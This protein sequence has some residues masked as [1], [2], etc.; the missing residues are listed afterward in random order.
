MTALKFDDKNTQLKK[1][2]R[3]FCS[4]NTSGSLGLLRK[5]GEILNRQKNEK[6]ENRLIVL[7]QL[8]ASINESYSG[9]QL[10]KEFS[11]FITQELSMTKTPE[12]VFN[13]VQKY[14]QD[15][16]DEVYSS[17]RSIA[18]RIK[19][20]LKEKSV[21]ITL[22]MSETVLDVLKSLHDTGHLEKVIVSESR[23]MNEGTSMAETLANYGIRTE[24]VVDAALDSMVDSADCAIIGSDTVYSDGSVSNKIGSRGLSLSCLD[25]GKPF[26]VL[27]QRRKFSREISSTFSCDEKPGT[28]I[29]ELSVS[30]LAIRNKYFEIIDPFLITGIITESGIV[31][32]SQHE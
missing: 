6:T 31:G 22:S 20:I 14:I 12:Q 23:P 1:E 24:L 26:Y 9:M 16:L 8:S 2:I 3:E 28:E 11:D 17:N 4:D 15:T 21:I 25:R 13:S 18:E 32:V 27:S 30:G 19:E 29:S 5:A 7:K 10:L